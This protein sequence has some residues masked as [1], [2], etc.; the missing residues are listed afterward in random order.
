MGS[1]VSGAVEGKD[2]W[3]TMAPTVWD[4]VMGEDGIIGVS[5][6]SVLGEGEGGGAVGNGE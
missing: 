5:D 6:G 4:A 1:M 3:G 2:C